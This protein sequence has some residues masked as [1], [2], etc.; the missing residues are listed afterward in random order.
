MHS[1]RTCTASSRVGTS[2][3]A[4]DAGAFA[5]RLEPFEDRDAEGGRLAGAGLRLAHQVDARQR[6]A[7]SSPAWIGVGSRYSASSKRGEH[8]LAKA[9]CAAKPDGLARRRELRLAWFR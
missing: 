5:M 7:E 9:P 4:C 6:A 1:S 3:R 2:T 8:D